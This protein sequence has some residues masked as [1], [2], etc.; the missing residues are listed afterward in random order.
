MGLMSPCDAS[1]PSSCCAATAVGL[2]CFALLQSQARCGVGVCLPVA[3]PSV[4]SKLASFSPRWPG[5]TRA[6]TE[7]K[8]SVGVDAFLDRSDSAAAD[9]HASAMRAAQHTGA[10]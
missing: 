1:P 7:D 10:S 5:T 8:R 2:R 9:V 6:G 4:L 3:T